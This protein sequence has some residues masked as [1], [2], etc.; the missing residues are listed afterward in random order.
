[1]LPAQVPSGL[2]PQGWHV[3]LS[4]GCTTTR[5]ALNDP[6]LTNCAS[7]PWQASKHNKVTTAPFI[8]NIDACHERPSCTSGSRNAA[9]GFAINSSKRISMG[10]GSGKECT[11]TSEARRAYGQALRLPFEHIPLKKRSPLV[12]QSVEARGCKVTASLNIPRC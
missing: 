12:W 5:E 2:Q 11:R 1:M 4:S 8:L 6:L 7:T 10:A 9:I 3:Q